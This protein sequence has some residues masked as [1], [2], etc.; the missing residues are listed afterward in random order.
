MNKTPEHVA[1]IQEFLEYVIDEKNGYPE[2]IVHEAVEAMGNMNQENS[3][4]LLK[5]YE[6]EEKTTTM[7]YETVF[8]AREL[9]N[10]NKA[11]DNG[12]TEGIDFKKLV[13]KTNDPA[14]PFNL[15]EEK[16]RDIPYLQAMLLNKEEGANYDL[17]QRYRA[18]FTLR[19]L[20]C[21]E[22]VVAI[23]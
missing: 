16:Y 18:L 14:P 9:I 17:F 23:S 10:W 11:T 3:L 6:D 15:K 8:L 13:Y 20:N 4:M 2:I 21:M 5:R 1:K 19:E 22:S 7:V 12:K